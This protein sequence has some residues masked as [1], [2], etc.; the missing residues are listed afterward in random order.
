MCI[1]LFSYR[2]MGAKDPLSS[3][4]RFYQ[5][6]PIKKGC[7]QDRFYPVFANILVYKTGLYTVFFR[8]SMVFYLYSR[9]RN[10]GL[11]AT[12]SS[13]SSCSTWTVLLSFLRSSFSTARA[14]LGLWARPS[15]TMRI[16][17]SRTTGWA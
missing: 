2:R 5:R 4:K 3:R 1:S 10:M 17:R 13:Y 16:I 6:F 8:L 9:S 12:T 7:L 15:R 14:S 11:M